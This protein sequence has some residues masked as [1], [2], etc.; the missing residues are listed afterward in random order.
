MGDNFSNIFYDAET[1]EAVVTMLY[2]GT[3][4]DHTFSLKWGECQEL[5]GGKGIV[6]EVL[7]N[8]WRDAARREYKKTVRFSLAGLVCRPAKLT[9]RTAPRFDV[10]ITIPARRDPVH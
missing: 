10:A 3:N 7:D 4:P 5:S 2:R 6:A 9:L 1:D 8:Q